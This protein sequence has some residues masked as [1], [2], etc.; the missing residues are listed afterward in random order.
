MISRN[1]H[2]R[3]AALAAAILLALFAAPDA[4]AQEDD[5]VVVSVESVDT[6]TA[7]EAF[8][9]LPQQDLEVLPVATRHDMV[10]YMK[11][12][13]CAR[14]RNVFMGMSWIEEMTPLYMRVH[15]SNASNLQI[16]LLPTP[17]FG[18]PIVMTVYTVSTDSITADSTVKFY[19]NEM[20]PLPESPRFKTLEPK[21]L[22]DIPKGS[23]VKLRELLDLM[24]FYTME[25]TASP[26]DTSLRGRTTI[27]DYLTDEQRRL[28]EPY[29][30]KEFL[31][32][33]DGK[34]F[35]LDGK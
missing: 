2:L 10:D 19:D 27:C 6:I 11:A 30:R 12:D 35:R 24:P 33:W 9:R 21:Q 26:A 16:R 15:L 1:S 32:N 22:Y 13:S 7:P 34:R 20:N 31:W 28:V 8:L 18:M 17:K 3:I 23:D 4:S 14:V 25:L 29:L 5:E